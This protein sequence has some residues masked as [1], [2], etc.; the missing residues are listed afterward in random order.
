VRARLVRSLTGLLYQPLTADQ[1]DEE[2]KGKL[3]Y[4]VKNYHSATFSMTIADSLIA[5]LVISALMNGMTAT[6][7]PLITNIQ[8]SKRM[9]TCHMNICFS[10]PLKSVCTL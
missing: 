9:H 4:S 6:T 2:R 7:S 5:L 8:A 3:K 10:V 1:W